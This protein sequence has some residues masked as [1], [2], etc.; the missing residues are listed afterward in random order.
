MQYSQRRPSI[1]KSIKDRLFQEKV[2]PLLKDGGLLPSI[3]R[4]SERYGVSVGSLDKALQE[5]CVEGYVEKRRGSGTYVLPQT[6]NGLADIGIFLDCRNRGKLI[7]ESFL[8]TLKLDELIQ[9]K[10]AAAGR[11]SR[12]YADLRLEE[13]KD[14]PPA[15]FMEDLERRKIS[16]LTT[17]GEL[18]RSTRRQTPSTPR[19]SSLRGAASRLSF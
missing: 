6:A 19:T 3:K 15:Q 4:L 14:A 2:V 17:A 8:F 1:Y 9:R 10:L 16:S 5:L 7:D 12:H 11:K 18:S 13:F